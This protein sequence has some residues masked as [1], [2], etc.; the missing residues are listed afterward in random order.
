VHCDLAESRMLPLSANVDQDFHIPPSGN[1]TELLLESV[2]VASSWPGAIRP[3]NG[4]DT[5]LERKHERSSPL[6]VS[7]VPKGVI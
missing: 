3:L 2:G 6:Q 5:E 7:V 1:C 4:W